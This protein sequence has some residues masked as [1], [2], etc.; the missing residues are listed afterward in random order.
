[1]SKLGLGNTMG[2]KLN[3]NNTD[4]AIQIVDQQEISDDFKVID[5]HSEFHNRFGNTEPIAH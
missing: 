5:G 4:N 2:N 3:N 1:M